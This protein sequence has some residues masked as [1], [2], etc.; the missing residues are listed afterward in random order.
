MSQGRPRVGAGRALTCLVG[1]AA[2]RVVAEETEI[3]P[4]D[5][6]L[7]GDTGIP[8]PDPEVS[9]GSKNWWDISSLQNAESLALFFDRESRRH[10][11]YREG[12]ITSSR[13]ALQMYY[14]GCLRRS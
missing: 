2:S 5:L 3:L 8:Y 1:L 9:G 12:H 14:F 6:G 10:F 11:V 7:G 13:K 4:S